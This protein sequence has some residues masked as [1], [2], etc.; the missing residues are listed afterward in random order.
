MWGKKENLFLGASGGTGVVA[1]TRHKKQEGYFLHAEYY[2]YD[3]PPQ[4]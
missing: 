4:Q 2:Y 3:L 1:A